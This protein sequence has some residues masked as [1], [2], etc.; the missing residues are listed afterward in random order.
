MRSNWFYIPAIIIVAYFGSFAAIK[1]QRPGFL[2]SNDGPGPVYCAVYLPLRFAVASVQDGYW[3]SLRA[4][5]WQTV[6]I[7]WNNPGNGYLDFDSMDGRPERAAF[8]AS[9]PAGANEGEWVNIHLR[10]ELQTWDDFSDH[11]IASID[12]AQKLAMGGK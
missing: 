1:L 7:V 11:L 6:K 2:A 5:H 8:A 12:R 9:D 3:K 4:G 10:Y